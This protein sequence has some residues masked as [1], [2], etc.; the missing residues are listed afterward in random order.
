MLERALFKV[1]PFPLWDHVC[2]QERVY[3]KQVSRETQA[4]SLLTD[5]EKWGKVL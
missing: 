1:L 2:T 5:R 3:Y 4:L